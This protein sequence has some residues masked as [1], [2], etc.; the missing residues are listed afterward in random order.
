MGEPAGHRPAPASPVAVALRRTLRAQRV[1]CAARG[2]E[3][4]DALVQ[5]ADAR[6]ELG[7]LVRFARQINRIELPDLAQ[8]CG[9]TSR[10]LARFELGQRW[11]E[12]LADALVTQLTDGDDAPVTTS[13]S[14]PAVS[15]ET[16][17]PVGTMTVADVREALGAVRGFVRQSD[18]VAA[19]SAQF[20]LYRDVLAAIAQGTCDAP[21]RC[22]R[23]ALKL[24]FQR[25]RWLTAE[26]SRP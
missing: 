14:A 19:H 23:E 17:T 24:E 10:V 7:G 20:E 15:G 25:S 8:R 1:L 26:S 2:D 13:G 4:R 6:R 9:V 5:Q 21:A 16:E 22:A 11:C 12:Q 18:H 3:V